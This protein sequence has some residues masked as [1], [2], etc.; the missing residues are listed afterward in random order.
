MYHGERTE[1]LRRTFEKPCVM[2]TES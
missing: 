1:D 2:R